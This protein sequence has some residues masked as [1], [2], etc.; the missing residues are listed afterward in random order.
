MNDNCLEQSASFESQESCIDNR[1]T[2]IVQVLKAAFPEK[3]FVLF[4]HYDAAAERRAANCVHDIRT[5]KGV[6]E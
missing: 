6:W 2:L 4:M 5:S 3:T 1:F